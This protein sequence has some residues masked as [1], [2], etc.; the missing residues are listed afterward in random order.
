MSVTRPSTEV[1]ENLTT[2]L[3]GEAERNCSLF[4]LLTLW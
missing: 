2:E 1:T 3:T 4:A